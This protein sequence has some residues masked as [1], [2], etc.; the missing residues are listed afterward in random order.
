MVLHQ[1]PRERINM[2]GSCPSPNARLLVRLLIAAAATATFLLALGTLLVFPEYT[3]GGRFSCST[4]LLM[5]DRWVPA[6]GDQGSVN[7]WLVCPDGH[8]QF[9]PYR[10]G[11]AAAVDWGAYFLVSFLAFFLLFRRRQ[12]RAPG[13]RR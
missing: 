13:A 1:P 8:G 4:P 3:P 10:P 11:L 7:R 6:D 5:S 12:R 2:P 9:H